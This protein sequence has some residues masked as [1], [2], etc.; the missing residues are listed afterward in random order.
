MSIR[1]DQDLNT[2]WRNLVEEY[3]GLKR[4]KGR[5]APGY[6]GKIHILSV[7]CYYHN[8]M[9]GELFACQLL[10]A[11]ARDVY[12]GADT[13]T[14]ANNKAVGKYQQEKVFD[15]GRRLSWHDLT[16]P[17]AGAPLSPEAFAEDFRG[18]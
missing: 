2:L 3:Q 14:C 1:P 13:V 7:P 15:P 18:K 6:A 16:R 17:T 5:N 12:N 9:M 8:Y 11:I 10:Q 4:S